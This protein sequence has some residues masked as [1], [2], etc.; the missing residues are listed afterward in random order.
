MTVKEIAELAGTSRGTVDRVLHNRPGVKKEVYERVLRVIEEYNFKPNTLARALSRKQVPKRIGI[1]INSCGNL[2]FNEVIQGLHGAAA[3]KA[4]YD[5]SLNIKEL[6]GYDHQKQLEALEE[7]EQQSVDGI[8]ITP[9]NHPLVIHRLR[10]LMARR[11]PV[12]TVNTDVEDEKARLDYIG[13]DYQKSGRLAGGVLELLSFHNS[14]RVGVV[15]GS[16]EIRGHVQRLEGFREIADALETVSICWEIC[17]QDDDTLAY[18][19]TKEMLAKDVPD[20]IYVVASGTFGVMKAIEESDC[21]TI[22]ITNDVLPVTREYMEKGI[23][24]ASIFQ[25]PYEQG[26][27]AVSRMIDHL[28]GL[29]DMDPAHYKIWMRIITR[30]H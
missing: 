24:K 27:N 22:A 11:I 25:Q 2:F 6:K 3:D 14:L 23:I 4:A 10:E 20:L 8:I 26:Y 18:Q 16:K 12:I 29:E 1:I 28:Y 30:Y 13:C 7:M 17:C 9:V 21:N 15:H 5:L 19:R